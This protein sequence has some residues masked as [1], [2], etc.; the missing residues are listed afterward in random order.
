[1]TQQY[2]LKLNDDYHIIRWLGGYVTSC[3]RIA[4]QEFQH[5]ASPLFAAGAFNPSTDALV[6]QLVVYCGASISRPSRGGAA[7]QRPVVG[8]HRRQ[9]L[10]KLSLPKHI[11]NVA[12]R[13]R[14][15]LMAYDISSAQAVQEAL[16]EPTI[17]QNLSGALPHARVAPNRVALCRSALLQREQKRPET[18][19]TLRRNSNVSVR[20][21][22]IIRAPVIRK[23]TSCSGLWCAVAG[24]SVKPTCRRLLLYNQLLSQQI[25]PLPKTLKVGDRPQK[26]RSLRREFL[27][28]IQH[29]LKG[30]HLF[31][32][33]D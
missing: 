21:C 22:P 13:N 5:S 6:V 7:L 23:P 19:I 10:C 14:Y 15:T 29:W 11:T 33:L 17:K 27:P 12:G 2:R 3:L 24:R 20:P 28:Q 30:R 1:M 4:F 26:R 32:V 9:R 25:A 31:C 16:A 8:R 18:H